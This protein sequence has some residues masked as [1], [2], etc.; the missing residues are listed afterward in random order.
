MGD[1]RWSAAKNRWTAQTSHSKL[2]K[3]WQLLQ[4]T[5]GVAS[6]A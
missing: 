1:P 3:L 5:I 4:A 6:H 2:C